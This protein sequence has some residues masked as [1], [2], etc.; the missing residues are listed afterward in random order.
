MIRGLSHGLLG[1]V[2]WLLGEASAA[3]SSFREAVRIQVAIGHRWG[4]LTSLE[5][6]AWVA[7]S[8]GR[9]ERAALLLGASAA[10]SQELGITLFPYGQAHHDRCEATV[11]AGLDEAGYVG[12]WEQG[13]ALGRD[14]VAAAALEDALA[15]DGRPPTASAAHD[16]DEL[17]RRELEV[18]R[19][20]ANGMSNPAIAADLFVSVATVKTH[21]SHILGKLGLQSRVQ[22]AQLGRHP[23]SG[24][25][26]L[27]RP[28]GLARSSPASAT[29]PMT[30][31]GGR[32]H[33]VRNG[34][35]TDRQR[36]DPSYVRHS[37][38]DASAQLL[39]FGAQREDHHPPSTRASTKRGGR[40]T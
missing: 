28:V 30:S 1:T 27:R 4:M 25:T 38:K 9:L 15:A 36:K 14:Q 3:E 29:R 19:L 32:E 26:D 5:G 7:G 31:A 11:R 23:R 39:G 24:S 17:S 22:L 13:Y 35:Y 21:V 2:E 20:V 6:L 40:G 10:L 34:T 16:P 18:A 37:S 12:C 8:S 33:R